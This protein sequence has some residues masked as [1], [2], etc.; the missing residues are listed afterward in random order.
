MVHE[1]YN[2]MLSAHALTALDADDLRTLEEHLATCGECRP[3]LDVWQATVAALALSAP[4]VEPSPQVRARILESVR[5]QTSV[6]TTARDRGREPEVTSTVIP[7]RRLHRFWTTTQKFAA[8]A[9][10]LAFVALIISIVV[11]W[12]QNRAAQNEIARLHAERVSVRQELERQSELVALLSKPTTSV[13]ALS[14]TQEAPNAHATLTYDRQ[15]G[16][17]VLLTN[18]LPR[19]PAGK[20]YQ[21]WFIVGNLPL[22]GR[23]FVADASGRAI[24]SDQIP[25][26]ALKAAVFAITLEPEGGVKAPTGPIYLR[27]VS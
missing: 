15:T 13:A 25:S 10:V 1:N 4:L 21:L 2:E 3:E 20:A 26:D 22:P 16:K 18:G 24:L 11:L 7:F 12:K 14:G 23:V 19:A 27:S 9:A 5:A 17:A 6:A 8:I